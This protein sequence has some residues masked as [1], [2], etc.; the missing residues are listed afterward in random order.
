MLLRFH[1]QQKKGGNHGKL[2]KEP[3]QVRIPIN[4]GSQIHW[5]NHFF[6][7][8]LFYF[9]KMLPWVHFTLNLCELSEI[10]L[11]GHVEKKSVYYT[12]IKAA[13]FW[14]STVNKKK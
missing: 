5:N 8:I 7:W 12:V 14:N 11:G 3:D 2:N 10:S 6:H 9:F 13:I 1:C 4:F